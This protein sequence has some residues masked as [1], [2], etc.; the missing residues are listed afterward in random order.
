MMIFEDKTVLVTGGAGFIGSTLSD[1]LLKSNLKKLFIFDNLSASSTDNIRHMLLDERVEFVR[2]DIRDYE[3][4]ERYVLQSD[5]VFNLAANN[6]GNSIINPRVDM[7][8]NVGGT[9]NVLQAA[10]KNP[11]VRIVHASSGSVL[12]SSEVPMVEDSVLKPTTFYAISKMSGEKYCK[13]FADEYGVKVSIIRYFHVFG[14]RQDMKG[15]CGVINIFLSDIINGKQPV[16]W[17]DGKQVKCF[18]YVRD[19][20]RATIMMAEKEE[21]IGEIYNVASDAIISIDD[22]AKLLIKRFALDKTMV[23]QYVAPKVGE[24]LRPVPDT[25]KIKTLGWKA[26]YTFLEGLDTSYEWVKNQIR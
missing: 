8:T 16:V 6:I 25:S 22:L 15:K 11:G 19:T 9:F 23:P 1:E 18:T 13:F 12:G 3:V 4:V 26:E 24:N 7:E 5:F 14:P 20:V 17:G 21:T 2:G 10:R